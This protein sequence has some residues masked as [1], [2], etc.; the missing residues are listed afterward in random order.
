MRSFRVA[1]ILLREISKRHR[2]G[3]LYYA[4]SPSRRG[5]RKFLSLLIDLLPFGTHFPALQGGGRKWETGANN[6]T[7]QVVSIHGTD[8]SRRMNERTPTAH[9]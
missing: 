7:T 2:E 4:L 9:P 5:R 6:R 1:E 3:I 8:D